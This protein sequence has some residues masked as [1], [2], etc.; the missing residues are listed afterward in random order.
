VTAE[1]VSVA[2]QEIAIV[3][4]RGKRVISLGQMDLLHQRP[5]G[6]AKRA[7]REH[8]SKLIKGED[9]FHIGPHEIAQ[10]RQEPEDEFRPLVNSFPSQ[11]GGTGVIFLTR[12]GYLLLVKSFS[13]DL[14]WQVQRELVRGY[15]DPTEKSSA[16]LSLWLCFNPRPWERRFPPDFYTEVLRLKCRELDNDKRTER[17]WGTIT[18]D[19]IYA[20]LGPSVVEALNAANPIPEGGK[21]RKNKHHQHFAQG[22]ADRQLISLIGECIGA[23]KRCHLWDEFHGFWD[24]I[25]PRFDTLQAEFAFVYRDAR[26]LLPWT[27]R[28]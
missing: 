1:L 5:E 13:D 24:S 25:H 7:F 19:L 10:L 8:R 16:D 23:M 22:A 28:N 17:W 2:G 20:R 21:W 18:K 11:G 12:D 3:L 27:P 6:T 9:Y 14:A 4:Y 26:I 15:F